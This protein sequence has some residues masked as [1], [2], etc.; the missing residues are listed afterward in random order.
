MLPRVIQASTLQLYAP[1]PPTSAAPPVLLEVSVLTPLLQPSLRVALVSIVQQGAQT[2]HS[3]LLGTFAQIPA[4]SNPVHWDPFAKQDEPRRCSVL[5]L[6]I[7]TQPPQKSNAT[8]KPTV[9]LAR[10]IKRSVPRTSIA[11]A[12]VRRPPVLPHTT[13]LLAALHLSS[14]LLE[15]FALTRTPK[16]FAQRQTTVLQAL[17][18]RI[19]AL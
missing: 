18:P 19:P 8:P 9:Q 6:I 7:A 17:S 15:V 2:S 16:P 4:Y 11:A 10:S 5:R 13:V 14:V 12:P 3:V 1:L